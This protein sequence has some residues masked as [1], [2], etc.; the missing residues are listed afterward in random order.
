MFKNDAITI[1]VFAVMVCALFLSA[2]NIKG[3]AIKAAPTLEIK[4]GNVLGSA[5]GEGEGVSELVSSFLDPA[6][7][8]KTLGES[9]SGVKIDVLPT[10]N[11]A[12]TDLPDGSSITPADQ[13]TYIV[14]F[15]V[16]NLD[17]TSV[18][19]GLDLSSA[20]DD[21]SSGDDQMLISPG[22]EIPVPVTLPASISTFITEINQAQFKLSIE[23]ADA[24]TAT[25]NA[26][27]SLGR[28]KSQYNDGNKINPD[29]AVVDGTD[30]KKVIYTFAAIPT[31]DTANDEFQMFVNLPQLTH[32][33]IAG[34]DF[35]WTTAE[36]N[37]PG[38]GEETSISFNMGSM[39][40]MLKGIEFKGIYGML[41]ADLGEGTSIGGFTLKNGSE[42]LVDNQPINAKSLPAALTGFAGDADTLG[43]T[44]AFNL[45]SIFDGSSAADLR[46]SFETGA[47]INMVNG[48]TNSSG[49]IALVI[50]LPL[51]FYVPVDNG[52]SETDTGNLVEVVADAST[53]PVTYEYY[54]KVEL[55]QL[56][57]LQANFDIQKMLGEYGALSSV[58]IRVNE[59]LNTSLPKEL[60]L[61]I[62]GKDEEGNDKWESP[63]LF[64]PDEGPQDFSVSG[65]ITKI[66]EFGIVVPCDTPT[67]KTT[68]ATFSIQ[69]PQADV[70][71]EFDLNITITATANVD[72]E[73][74][75]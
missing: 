38:A 43:S 32:F 20:F 15:E 33:A 41:F 26:N 51:T 48:D 4:L 17:I 44:P 39:L 29:S 59:V 18:I 54:R 72:Y 1:G 55:E 5:M 66:P 9:M 8:Q 61:S 21:F 30:E 16:A 71:S 57:S 10:T 50:I 23:Y 64:D 7:L 69:P 62:K 24:A 67:D 60:G 40:D 13:Q 65:E 12:L 25:A 34:L 75:L 3:V 52:S 70:K 37:M 6:A 42:L 11:A 53:D 45:T 68:V 36:F 47:K 22:T 2:C 46:Y 28:V 73:I 49:A 35:D 19:S 63:I 14:E 58:G 27:V 31:F 56:S 74:K